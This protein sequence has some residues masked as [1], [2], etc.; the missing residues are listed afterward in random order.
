MLSSKDWE[1]R[2]QEALRRWKSL[3]ARAAPV[4]TFVSRADDVLKVR[5]ATPA[6]TL[7]T[8]KVPVPQTRRV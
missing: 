6:E 2:L 8:H 3:E 4:E 1:R 7:H 5:G